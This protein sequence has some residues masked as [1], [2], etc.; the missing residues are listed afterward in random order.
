[1]VICLLID[2]HRNIAFE[3]A[4]YIKVINVFFSIISNISAILGVIYIPGPLCMNAQKPNTLCFLS[5]G[6]V[7]MDVSI[8]LQSLF[9]ARTIV[10][11]IQLHRGWSPECENEAPRSDSKRRSWV[12]VIH[13]EPAVRNATFYCGLCH[14][15]EWLPSSHAVGSSYNNVQSAQWFEF[16]FCQ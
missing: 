12:M 14:C 9:S 15:Y 16:Q 1:M 3:C 2:N 8:T 7:L 5:I 6:F 13:N 10:V 11:E 4:K